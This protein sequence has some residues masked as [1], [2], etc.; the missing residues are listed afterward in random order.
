MTQDLLTTDPIELTQALIRCPSVTPQ[1]GGALD[2]LQ[3]VLE[4]AGFNCHRLVFS[5]PD[6][7]DVDNLYARLGTDAPHLCFAGHTDVVPPGDE[8]AWSHPPFGG[9]VVDGRLYGRGAADMKGG[10]ACFLAAALRYL[11]DRQNGCPGSI[12]FLITGDEEGP[13][14]NGT[15]KVLEWLKARGERLDHCLLGEPSNP[16]ALGEAIK[17]GRRGSLNGVLTISGKQGHVAYPDLAANPVPGLLAVLNRFLAE[18]LDEGN[19]HF[20]PSNLEVTSIDVGNKAENVIPA[21]AAAMF[22]IRFNDHHTADSLKAR[23]RD[24]AGETLAKFDL[25]HSFRFRVTGGCFL[26]EPGPL[27][28]ALRD[29]IREET[30]RTPEL[31]TGGG[32]SD[33]RFIKDYCP[34]I[35]F[36]L[37][38]STIHAV[39]EHVKVAD[40]HQLTAIY[41]RFIARYFDQFSA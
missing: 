10:V 33:A 13:A 41:E 34:V 32:T 15:R 14:L 19:T 23:L 31:S 37:I 22:N 24:L 4:Q 12:S 11:R 39:D 7:P 5:E 2:F 8:K 20:T 1:E 30:G 38:N 26:T 35:E 25:S 6:T 36:G 3:R 21:S 40:L 17:I 27:V 18:P 9:D 28:D 29:T 16:A